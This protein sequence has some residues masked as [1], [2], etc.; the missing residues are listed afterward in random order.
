METLYSLRVLI[1]SS[2]M[3]PFLKKRVRNPKVYKLPLIISTCDTMAK[4]KV[5][6]LCLLLVTLTIMADAS[7]N[8]VI[9]ATDNGKT[10]SLKTGDT[11][12]LKLQENPSTGYSW[13]L[14]LSQGLRILCDKY[15]QNPAPQGIVGVPGTHL[16]IIKA[17]TQGNKHVIGVYK[18]PWITGTSKTV[19]AFAFNIKSKK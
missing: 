13:Q 11:F 3:I 18:R 16:W 6:L 10:I 4:T 7:D 19:K 17:I 9:K 2:L 1:F 5:L 14:N 8:K 12:I 15:I